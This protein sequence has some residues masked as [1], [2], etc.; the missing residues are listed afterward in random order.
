MARV[1]FHSD[2]RLEAEA[3]P[4]HVLGHLPMPFEGKTRPPRER[5]FKGHLQ[6][7]SA[8]T[9]GAEVGDPGALS[10]SLIHLSEPP[11]PY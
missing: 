6:R 3:C 8:A 5:A 10:L 11:R 1:P 2:G 4:Y 7:L 9:G